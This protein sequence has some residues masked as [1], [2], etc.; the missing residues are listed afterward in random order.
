MP[1]SSWYFDL[2]MIEKYWGSDRVYHHTAPVS[3]ILALRESLRMVFEEGSRARFARHVR[4]RDG[5]VT[6]LSALGLS[7]LVPPDYRLP[8]L[9]SVKVP[10]NVDEAAIRR[11]LLSAYN[12]EIGAGL[13]P[14]AGK[15]WRIGLMGHSS[16]SD[17]VRSV[18]MA[19]GE[20]LRDVG[21]ACDPD[22]AV[23]AA[24]SVLARAA[25]E[26]P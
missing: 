7:L 23:A 22:E 6:G 10:E 25:I 15:I 9:T 2:G 20:S 26:E 13:G 4:H 14:L 12:I 3:M 8:M 5:L 17:N 1:V 16:R 19:L 11:R 21:H 18:L 24:D